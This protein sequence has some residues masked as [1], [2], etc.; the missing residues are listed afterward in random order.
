MILDI[1]DLAEAL[2]ADP[3]LLFPFL[4]GTG[5]RSMGSNSYQTVI[6]RIQG[7]SFLVLTLERAIVSV[8]HPVKCET[9]HYECNLN[10]IY[11]KTL[12][13]LLDSLRNGI[14]ML[15]VI[16]SCIRHHHLP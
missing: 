11:L 12:K 5:P 6:L 2:P 9:I 7:D 8:C 10:Y 1:T 3:F 15:C 13:C 14:I 4:S 16:N